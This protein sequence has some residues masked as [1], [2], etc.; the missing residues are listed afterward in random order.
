MAAK[1]EAAHPQEGELM[2]C[3]FCS[4]PDPAWRYPAVSFYDSFG[5]RSVEDWLACEAC[6]QMIA[7]SDRNGLARRSLCAPG[8]QMAVGLLGRAF[9]LDYCRDLHTRFWQARRGDAFRMSA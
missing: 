7:A 5:G 1:R 3:D 8:V 9:A 6:H 2:I 4:G